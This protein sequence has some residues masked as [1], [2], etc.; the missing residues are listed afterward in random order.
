VLTK[1][2][3]SYSRTSCSR[4]ARSQSIINLRVL[5]IKFHYEHARFHFKKSY[6]FICLEDEHVGDV[7]EVEAD[8]LLNEILKLRYLNVSSTFVSLRLLFGQSL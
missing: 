8:E 1:S 4:G 3:N 5:E 6:S 2:R 7:H